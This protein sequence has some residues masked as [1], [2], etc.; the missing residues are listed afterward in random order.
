MPIV[1][2]LKPHTVYMPRKQN[3][4]KALVFALGGVLITFTMILL[5]WIATSSVE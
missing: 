2:I 4:R 5:V 3:E 1:S